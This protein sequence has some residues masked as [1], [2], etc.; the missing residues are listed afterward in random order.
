MKPCLPRCRISEIFVLRV[1]NRNLAADQFA[2]GFAQSVNGT[3]KAESE[4]ESKVSVPSS[5]L[6]CVICLLMRS[7]HQTGLMASLPRPWASVH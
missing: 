5:G 7:K 1:G 2:A 4:M 6:L 3:D